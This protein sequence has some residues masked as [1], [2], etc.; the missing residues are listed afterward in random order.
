MPRPTPLPHPFD[1]EPFRVDAA[2]RGTIS[3]GRLRG[4]DLQ[5]PF[6]GVRSVGLDLNETVER[7]AAYSARMRSEEFFSHTTAAILH[8]FPLPRMLERDRRLHVGVFVPNWPPQARGVAGHLFNPGSVGVTR[9][10]A[11]RSHPVTSPVHTWCLLGTALGVEDLVA[12]GDFLVKRVRPSAT[13]TEL[14]EGVELFSGRRGV[15]ALRSALQLVR[16]GTDSRAE[17]HLRL[18]VVRWGFPEPAVNYVV[19]NDRGNFV[20]M[21]DLAFVEKRVV[22]EY[23]GDHHRTDRATF[24]S[25]IE[26]RERLEDAGWVVIRVTGDDLYRYPDRLAARIRRRL[27]SRG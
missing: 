9:P 6:H 25:D 20:A 12:V 10:R 16:P 26:R 19:R 11:H 1:R 18:L 8:G 5:R 7:C 23:E 14:A 13:M 2:L 24:R 27:A 21:C 22:L 17:S 3:R 15:G 4:S